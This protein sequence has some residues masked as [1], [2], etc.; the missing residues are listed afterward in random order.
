MSPNASYRTTARWRSASPA[1]RAQRGDL[2]P[3]PVDVLGQRVVARRRS[4]PRGLPGLQGQGERDEGDREG[5]PGEGVHGPSVVI[6]A[7]SSPDRAPAPWKM[8][9]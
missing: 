5:E 7:R 4:T 2:L 3:Q 1:S 8:S 9:P 6:G